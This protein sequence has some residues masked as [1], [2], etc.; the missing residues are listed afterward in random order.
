MIP[1]V[2][3]LR[4]GVSTVRELCQCRHVGKPCPSDEQGW[5][6]ISF[7]LWTEEVTGVAFRFRIFRHVAVS[8][9]RVKLA[10]RR[11]ECREAL[12]EFLN[13]GSAMPVL[14]RR[15]AAG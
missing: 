1:T 4:D 12:H 6:F 5:I 11:E 13:R 3:A 10:A 9:E 15:G 14:F 7:L 8:G 2:T